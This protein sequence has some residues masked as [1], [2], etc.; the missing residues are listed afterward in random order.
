M[1]VI[2]NTNNGHPVP[3]MKPEDVHFVQIFSSTFNVL[4][5]HVNAVGDP[6]AG[7]WVNGR[8]MGKH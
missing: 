2:K 1:A 5:T 4:F 6:V 3:S 8:I 7:I